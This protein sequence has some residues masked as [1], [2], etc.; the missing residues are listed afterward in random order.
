[1]TWSES[2]AIHLRAEAWCA[3]VLK[4]GRQQL[5]RIDALQQQSGS[6]HA[7]V[8]Q[9]EAVH[10]GDDQVGGD[11]RNARLRRAAKQP[12][13]LGMILIAETDQRDP[14]AAIDEHA[15]ARGDD[16]PGTAPVSPQRRSPADS[17]RTGRCSPLAGD[18]APFR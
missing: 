5:A 9:N 16:V 8:K 11:Q 7:D 14:R 2:L 10:L 6:A 12:I 1:M 15:V 4:L 3:A 13:R 18:P 17:D